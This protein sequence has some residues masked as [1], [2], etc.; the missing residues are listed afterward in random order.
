MKQTT[1]ED[2]MGRE[3][4]FRAWD[5]DNKV[6]FYPFQI[7]FKKTGVSVRN[8]KLHL[9]NCELMQFTG[10]LDI[11]G[12]E[13]YE[14]DILQSCEPDIVCV[15]SYNNE[16]AKFQAINKKG[17]VGIDTTKWWAREIIGNIYQNPE[18]LK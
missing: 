17:D 6:M 11:N 5:I 8:D 7:Q 16:W 9:L 18:L 1:E 4:K 2:R 14:G 3:I 10:L 12:L 13:I 15:V